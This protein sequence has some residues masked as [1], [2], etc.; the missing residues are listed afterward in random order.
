MQVIRTSFAFPAPLYQ[1]LMR[2]SQRRKQSLS[3]TVQ[4]LLEPMLQDEEEESRQSIYSA[5]H[6]M[7]G[8]CKA[9]VTDASQTIDQV[10]YGESST[11]KQ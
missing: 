9:D 3:K 10:V 2:L 5:F 4:S 8:I 7:Q 1:R 11:E 6:E